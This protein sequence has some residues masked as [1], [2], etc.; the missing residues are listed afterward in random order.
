MVGYMAEVPHFIP[1]TP[2]GVCVWESECKQVSDVKIPGKCP[3]DPEGVKCCNRPQCVHV[4]HGRCPGPANIKYIVRINECWEVESG[5]CPGGP[6]Y[7]KMT[8]G[9]KGKPLW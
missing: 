3:N 5:Q 9:P 2:P 7:M 8:R 1:L 4:E 6:S